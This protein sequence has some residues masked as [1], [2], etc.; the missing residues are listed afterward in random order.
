MRIVL[1]I[2]GAIVG[3]F[4][5]VIIVRV[6]V[7]G[8]LANTGGWTLIACASIFVTTMVGGAWAGSKIA[9]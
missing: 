6:I 5:G 4:V 8:N 3:G 2:A 7:A 9:K 1:A